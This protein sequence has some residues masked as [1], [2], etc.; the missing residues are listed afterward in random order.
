MGGYR[1]TGNVPGVVS[2][3]VAFPKTS[4]DGEQGFSPHYY[5]IWDHPT[6]FLKTWSISGLLQG[7]RFRKAFAPLAKGFLSCGP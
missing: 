1:G 2:S 4:P 6:T 3:Q 7:K 5:Y